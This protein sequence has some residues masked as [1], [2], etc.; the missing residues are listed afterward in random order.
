MEYQKMINLL[1]NVSNQLP[2]FRAKN[3]IEINDQSRG[4]Y[5]TDSNI[6]CKTQCVSLVYVIIVM[7]TY[8][9]Q[10]E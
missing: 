3:W 9:L 7:H 4:N 8:L 1:D 2:K 10:N 6:T 5:N